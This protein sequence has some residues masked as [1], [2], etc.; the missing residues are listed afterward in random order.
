ML[1]TDPKGEIYRVTASTLQE[2][3]YNIKLLNFRN[4][5][6]SECWNP[7]TP[8]FRKYKAVNNIYDEVEI[9]N[10]N[11]VYKN[12]FRGKV[13]DDQ[14]ELDSDIDEE[15]SMLL[16]DVE[17]DI[18]RFANMIIVTLDKHEPI[19]EDGARDIFRAFLY[20]MLEDSE[21]EENPITEETF[22]LSTIFRIE[23]HF[24]NGGSEFKDYGYFS[25]RGE[26]SKAYQLVKNILFIP[27]NITRSCYLSVLTTKLTE[28]REVTTRVITSCNT[29]DMEELAE[30]DQPVAIFI[31]FKDEL[32]SQFTTISLFVQD[33]YRILI[34]KANKMPNGRLNVPWILILD[35]F[36]NFTKIKDMDNVISACGGRNV[37]FLLIMQSYAQ[38]ENVYGRE[39]GEIIRDNMN[40]H[41]FMGSNN[42]STLDEFSRECGMMTRISPLSALNGRENEIEHYQLETIPLMPISRLSHFGVGECILTEAN[43]GYVLLSMFE[44]YYLCEEFSSLPKANEDDYVCQ[45]NPLDK[46]YIYNWHKKKDDDD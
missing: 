7:L 46:K 18:D 30:G 10:D 43:S 14:Q 12:K 16:S 4:Y 22:S 23:S 11:G 29:F 15:R 21:D 33:A 2:Q 36:G 32:K 9:I 31:D 40:V 20:A 5:K 45:I 44:R 3:G 24:Q 35:E 17:C 8:I 26:N 1:I 39:C 42:P 37:W 34:E 13:Y 6:R 25:D 41:I 27:A 38:L 19:W 28:Y